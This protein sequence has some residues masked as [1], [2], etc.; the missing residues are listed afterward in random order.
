MREVVVAGVGLCR[1]RR[2]DGQKGR[3]YK[4]YY[5]IGRTAVWNALKDSGI[6]WKE[7][8]GGVS[9]KKTKEAKLNS[10]YTC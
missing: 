3:A 2:Y 1:F 6:E 4:T 8:Q 7:I 5:E 10:C 9:H